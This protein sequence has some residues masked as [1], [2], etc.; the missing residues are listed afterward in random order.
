MLNYPTPEQRRSQTLDPRFH[1]IARVEDLKPI[2]DE[3]NNINTNISNNYTNLI[4]QL[5]QASA[6]DPLVINEFENTLGTITTITQGVGQYD[7]VCTGAFPDVDKI[8]IAGHQIFSGS[9]GGYGPYRILIYNFAGDVYNYYVYYNDANSIGISLVTGDGS[10]F[11]TNVDFFDIFGTDKLCFPE[12][13]I[14]N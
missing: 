8:Y 1:L 11:G 9:L 13:R 5:T 12:I 10:G 3:I 6:I 7:I 14:Y 4:C 2:I